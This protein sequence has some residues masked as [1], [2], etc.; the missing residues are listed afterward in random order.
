MTQ[1]NGTARPD[2]TT[3]LAVLVVI[4]LHATLAWLG[5]APGIMTGQDD[6]QYLMLAQSLR[7]GGYHEAFRVDRPLHALYPPGYPLMLALAGWP[8]ADRYD[9]VVAFGVAI[10]G[11]SLGIFFVALS[12]RLPI[13]V[14]LG[15][16]ALLAVNPDLTTVAGTISSEVG[17]LALSALALFL[18]SQPDR[19]GRGTVATMA[20]AVA[21]A[22]TRVL[23]ITL[24]G[25]LALHWFLDR[26][27]RALA[28]LVVTS[29][30]TVGGWLLWTAIAPD[31]H[32]GVSYRA[33]LTAGLSTS[34]PWVEPLPGRLVSNATFYAKRLLWTLAMPNVEGT[35]VDN[36]AGVALLVVLL[37][38]GTGALW[39]RWRL[40]ALYLAS[41]GAL[42]AIWTWA[43]GR[44]LAPLAL[45][46][47]PAVVMG[48]YALTSRFAPRWATIAV[49]VVTMMLGGT[50]LGRSVANAR[51][52]AGCDRGGPT[53]PVNCLTASQASFFEA[54]RYIKDSTPP[55]A[56]FL[57]AKYATLHHYTGR[58]AVSYRG[59]LARDS[60]DF[61]PFLDGNRVRYVLL[62][63]LELSEFNRLGPL[64]AKTC[65]R[66][67]VVRAFDPGTWL[68]AT[69]PDLAAPACRAVQEHDRL[70][71]NRTF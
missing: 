7:E 19:E 17:Y 1:P 62:A 66:L 27:W 45:V 53:P 60:A 39:R 40:A 37:A 25:A 52:M 67:S 28:G 2:R 5:R 13:S 18:A 23:G 69:T 12:R 32:V 24:I 29:A 50:A 59:A 63:S 47:V 21:A 51:A 30:L 58:T 15:A 43:Q 56:V 35:P 57:T 9:A 68:L 36:V 6:A 64:L 10:S 34:L 8:F 20:A 31:Q 3:M 55:D 71:R 61:L 11:L 70:N 44:Y 54:A 48:A 41:Y 22:L 42:L 26:R 65:H 49:A 4:V 14:A 46:V 16:T 38:V 33:D